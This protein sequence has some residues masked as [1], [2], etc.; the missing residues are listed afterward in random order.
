MIGARRRAGR[1]GGRAA[2]DMGG[3]TPAFETE[4]LAALNRH[5]ESPGEAGLQAAYE[6]GRR[7]LT[8]GIG[9]LELV[10]LH[11]RLRRS[12]VVPEGVSAGADDFVR[13]ALASYEVARRGYAE[14]QQVVAVERARAVALRTLNDA[15]LAVAAEPT[16]RSRLD[17]VCRQARQ[18]VDAADAVVEL[19]PDAPVPTEG[20]RLVVDLPARTGPARLAVTPQPGRVFAEADRAVLVQL[21]QLA[22]GAID[23]ARLLEVEQE[24]RRL[25]ER[26]RRFTERL[27]ELATVLAAPATP[28][29]V[30]R[31][32]LDDGLRLVDAARGTVDPD[33]AGPE[34]LEPAFE[35]AEARLPLESVLGQGRL[36]LS[37]PAPQPFDEDQQVFL[38][39]VATRLAL[40]L[41]RA[42]LYHREWAARLQAEAARA[43]I[44][45][46]QRFAADLSVARSR[47]DVAELLLGQARTRFG[48][49][50]A[51][52]LA[53]GTGVP[54]VITHYG[55][56][57]PILGPRLVAGAVASADVEESRPARAAVPAP[58]ADRVGVEALALHP[59][60]DGTRTVAVL[61]L[62]WFD[63]TTERA[64]EGEASEALL[65]LAAQGFERARLGDVD[66]LI[67]S[68]LQNE[69]L[70]VSTPSE[71]FGVSWSARYRAGLA[72][73]SA[74]GDWFDVLDLGD[75]QVGFLIGDVVGHGIDAT[76][77]MAQLRSAARALAGPEPGPLLEALD[78]FVGKTQAGRFASVAYVV[79]DRPAEELRY[80]IAGHPPPLLQLPSGEIH[81]LREAPGILLGAGRWA[82]HT[83]TRPGLKP[84][85]RLLLYTDGLVER[86][87]ES[88]EDGLR[89]LEATLGDW[90]ATVPPDDLADA[91]MTGLVTDRQ[92]DDVALVVV[93]IE[94]AAG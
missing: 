3:E 93:R 36:T 4:Y 54:E 74:G 8:E 92:A 80:A 40:A 47:L 6:L 84:G 55:L 53:P 18:L 75:G 69:F 79:V 22:Q 60:V 26:R 17:E 19:D 15:A 58:D 82:R 25:E 30:V 86:R 56:P 28:D 73:A 46:L 94:A 81:H 64:I 14:A 44:E 67:A 24:Q 11:Q 38:T 77:Q 45:S 72:G 61:A 78:G 68:T 41:D 57:D 37:F 7:A 63:P 21:A 85:S 83:S 42:E 9:L 31:R 34:D 65:L 90:P 2:K 29:V 51:A 71:L 52:V 20:R 49:D 59:L 88:I 10:E 87:G 70:M 62:G 89:R 48:A 13:E 35:A 23:D 50:V 76:G 66:H 91:L 27:A 16:V 39:G 5:L 12:L 43:S 33:G 1:S 32:F